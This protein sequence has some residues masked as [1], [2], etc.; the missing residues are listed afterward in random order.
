MSNSENQLHAYSLGLQPTRAGEKNGRATLTNDIV[1][2]LKEL[3]NSGKSVKEVAKV[4]NISLSKTRQIIY[5]SS[6]K[7]NTTKIIKRDDRRKTV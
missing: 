4:M 7:S 3:Y 6:W 1:T 2:I 5:G